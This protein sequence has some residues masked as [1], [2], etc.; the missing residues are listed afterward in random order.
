MPQY[1][2]LIYS[3]DVDWSL[4]ELRQDDCRVH[5]V[6]GRGRGRAPRRRRA[7]PDPTATAVRVKGGKGGDVVT[8]D[9]PYAETKEALTGFYLVEAAD[10]DE[11]IKVAATIPGRVGRRDRGPAGHRVRR[12][13]R[14]SRVVDV[15]GRRGRAPGPRGVPAHPRHARPRHRRRHA[16]RGRR[17][18]R[19]GP[20][21]PA[22]PRDGVPDEPRAWLTTVA[23]RC[24]IDRIR[25]ESA[26][27]GKEAEAVWLQDVRP[28]PSRASCA[29]T[30]CG[31]CSP[32][33]TRACRPTRR[34]R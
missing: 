32:A 17:A 20:R 33:A 2:A 16:R 3:R 11:A 23:R 29:T 18:G 4:P 22:W 7:V 31:S 5:G 12:L 34:S 1:A 19:R 28:R 13:N 15:A 21:A 25:R 27:T 24:A 26:R 30:C 6:R 8:T 14:A 10:L 9:G